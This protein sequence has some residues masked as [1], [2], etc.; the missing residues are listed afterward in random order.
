MSNPGELSDFDFK[1]LGTF[2]YTNFGINL[3]PKKKVLL[4]SR[5]QKR[6]KELDIPTYG[7]YCKFVLDHQNKEEVE[8]LI[9]SVSTNKT[10]FF[11]ES[12]HID[13]LNDTIA[14]DFITSTGNTMPFR[15]WCAGCSSGEE[16]YSI[17]MSLSQIATKNPNFKFQILASDISVDMLHIA[18]KGIYDYSKLMEIPEIYH[19]PYLLKSKKHSSMQIRMNKAIRESVSFFALNLMNENYEVG[20]ALDTIFC[21]NTLIYFDRETQ[22]KVV[23]KLFQ[24]LKIGGYLV[25]GHSESLINMDIPTKHC[26]PSVYQKL[27]DY[28]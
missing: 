11:R 13:Y 1:R 17:S 5:L 3:Y 14:P 7:A 25:L 4:Q 27:S 6:L 8:R 26:I 23:K 18:H 19:Q 2:I 10:S 9:V 15:I 22:V 28:K 20:Q 16:P 21:R 12:K 24:N